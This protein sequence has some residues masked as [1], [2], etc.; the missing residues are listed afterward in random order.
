MAAPSRAETHVARAAARRPEQLA[1]VELLLHHLPEGRRAAHARHAAE[2]RE[3]A[4]NRQTYRPY[5]P[6]AQ[7]ASALAPQA[8]MGAQVMSVRGGARTAGSPDADGMMAARCSAWRRAGRAID[9][10]AAHRNRR[11]RR[12]SG[13]RRS[14][15]AV[16]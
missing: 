11:R 13:A 3:Y 5:A 9:T 16:P 1:S 12:A 10:D 15:G 7:M 2:N 4:E 14:R 8:P 6:Q